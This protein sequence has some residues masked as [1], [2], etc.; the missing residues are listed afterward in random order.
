MKGLLVYLAALVA[1]VVAADE[2][3]CM[4]GDA[5]WPSADD[6]SQFNTTVGGRLVATVPLGQVCHDPSYNEAACNLVKLRW[7]DAAIQ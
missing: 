7:N 6:W 2:C 3:K 1:G 5:C 4:P